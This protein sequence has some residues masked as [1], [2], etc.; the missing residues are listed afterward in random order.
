MKKIEGVNGILP[1]FLTHASIWWRS[2]SI[3]SNIVLLKYLYIKW[4][5]WQKIDKDEYN[6]W[7]PMNKLLIIIQNIQKG[8]WNFCLLKHKSVGIASLFTHCYINLFIH[9]DTNVQLG[10]Y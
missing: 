5:F 4:Y 8:K 6:G 9:W 1:L 10:S 7:S 3:Q 2:I